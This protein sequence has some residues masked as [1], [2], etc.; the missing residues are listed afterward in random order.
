MWRCKVSTRQ[1]EGQTAGHA[2]RHA[3]KAS[4]VARHKLPTVSYT[5][6]GTGTSRSPQLPLFQMLGIWLTLLSTL[7]YTTSGQLGIQCLGE[8]RT[9]AAEVELR[10]LF[11]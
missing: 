3:S 11:L 8:K 4:V 1:R 9:R 2:R 5:A 10:G 7:T 6:A